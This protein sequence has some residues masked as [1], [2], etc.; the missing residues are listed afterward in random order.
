MDEQTRLLPKN[1]YT[2]EIF[3]HNELHCYGFICN[4]NTQDFFLDKYLDKSDFVKKI[5]AGENQILVL[6]ASGKLG[7]LGDNAN[8]QL[9]LPLKRG[10]NEN[11]YNEIFIYKPKLSQEININNYEII[12]IAAGEHFSLILISLNNKHFLYK[13]GYNQEDR[14]RDDIDLIDPIVSF[15]FEVFYKSTNN[16]NLI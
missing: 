14:Y 3:E 8:G 13:L 5:T 10:E 7:I 11:K 2:K 12:D 1:T 6:F 4:Q 15:N 9:G 16:Q